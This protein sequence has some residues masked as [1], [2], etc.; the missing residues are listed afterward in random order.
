[1]AT[2][3]IRG[4]DD[5]LAARLKVEAQKRGLG[6]NKYLQQLLAHA[7]SGAPGG[8]ADDPARRNDLR[9]LAGRWSAR[10]AREFALAVEPFA[11]ID[12]DIWQ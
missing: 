1:M 5:G 3:I 12:P 7:M 10:Q 4:F 11:V 2:L 9:K 8:A 6:L